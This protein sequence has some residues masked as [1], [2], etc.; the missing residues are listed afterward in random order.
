MASTTSGA[1][2]HLRAWLHIWWPA[3]L[4]V[5]VIIRE[6]TSLF[7]GSHTSWLIRPLWTFLFGSVSDA[8]WEEIHF[9]LRKC[10]H[11]FWYGLTGLAFLRAWR[12]QWSVYRLKQ[13]TMHRA[14][15]AM[16]I[17]CTAF[18]ASADELHQSYLS[19]RTGQL[20]DVLLDTAG[21]IVLI[22][23]TRMISTLR[24][25]RTAA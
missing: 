14:V 9:T 17:F 8:S 24:V 13:K 3:I 7:S 25:K 21:A 22:T 5:A 23:I 16:A 20:S 15:T 11:F 6:S 4:C 10:G 19:D 18:V 2:R 1:W 12:L